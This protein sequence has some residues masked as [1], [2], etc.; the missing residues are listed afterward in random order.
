M[1]VLQVFDPPMCCSTGACG[2]NVNPALT[3]FAADIDW[4]KSQ[5]VRVERFNPHPAA[6]RICQKVVLSMR[7][8]PGSV[9]NASLSFLSMV[10]S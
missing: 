8:S 2:P 3:Q 4:L 10:M 9:Q 1:V 7:Y 5:G 6:R